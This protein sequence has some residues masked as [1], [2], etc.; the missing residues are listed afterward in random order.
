MT[1]SYIEHMKLRFAEDPPSRK[2]L[3]TQALLQ[4]AAAKVLDQKGYHGLRITDVTQ[5]AA[6][7][8]GVFYL[9]FKDKTAVTL[10][11]LTGMLE[12][13]FASR[14]ARTGAPTTAEAI[15]KANRE[16]IG[17][18][19]ENAGLMRC[20]FQLADEEPAFGHLLHRTNRQ[21]IGR[22]A[23]RFTRR[24]GGERG[25]LFGAYL[26]G[27]MM[28]EIVRKLIVYPDP[29]FLAVLSELDADDAAVADGATLMWLKVLYAKP[30]RLEGLSLAAETLASWIDA[31]DARPRKA[32]KPRVKAGEAS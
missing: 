4:I 31:K 20:V 14:M 8:E 12:D 18:C 2:G 30:P 26:L 23:E 7:A 1:F 28:D 25:A 10:S 24:G 9:Y 29:E 13:F 5:A 22:V 3:R 32:A 6:V 11:V 21:W 16:W 15:R 19:R 27:S 17:L